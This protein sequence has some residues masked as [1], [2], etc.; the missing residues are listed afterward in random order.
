MPHQ[1]RAAGAAAM[2]ALLAGGAPALAADDL[3]A[4]R[5]EI[6]AM[7]HDYE[8]KIRRLEARLRK[9]EADARAAKTAA[10]RSS[11]RTA[12]PVP[13]IAPM[14]STTEPAQPVI[15]TTAAAP[16]PEP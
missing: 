16:V 11:S 2:L 10:A 5:R 15:T 3:A 14:Q 13:A 6:G 9:A 4:I 12:T 7:R 1:F 8:A